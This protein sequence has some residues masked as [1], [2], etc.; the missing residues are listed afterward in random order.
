MLL[1]FMKQIAILVVM[2]SHVA[3]VSGQRREQVL[4]D[5]PP[6]VMPLV[7]ALA[8]D[9]EI[10]VR[11]V[12]FVFERNLG[13]VRLEAVIQGKLDIAVLDN[14]IDLAFVS[15]EGM[16]A[17][18]IARSAVVFALNSGVPVSDLTKGQICDI[19]SGDVSNWKSLG[20]PDL[21][22]VP[23]GLPGK[24]MDAR[25]TQQAIQ[26]FRRLRESGLVKVI[27]QARAMERAL[28]A[29]PG[30]IGITSAIVVEQSGGRLRSI[31]VDGVA[32]SADNVDQGRYPIVREI[33]FIS[34]SPPSA[35]VERFIR[36]V[37]GSEGDK[38]I[39]IN[40]A[41]PAK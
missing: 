8:K 5:G 14:F 10:R 17:H 4:I 28:V 23:H 35:A 26:C 11:D 16:V 7:T 3:G 40:G 33:Y 39:R 36:F 29:T 19:Y 15:R 31:N 2:A 25:I 38:L 13:N 32:P 20:G 18:K 9:F 27:G 30:A 34:W 37:R 12:G 1:H 21:A 6:V 22:I 41:V 24:H